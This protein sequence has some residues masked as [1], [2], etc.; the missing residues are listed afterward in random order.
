MFTF[1]CGVLYSFL[2]SK[3]SAQQGENSVEQIQTDG[4]IG[5]R[6]SGGDSVHALEI[7]DIK[8]V[9]STL[10]IG[11]RH[12]A[13][14]GYHVRTPRHPEDLRNGK[15]AGKIVVSD[16]FFAFSKTTSGLF[17]RCS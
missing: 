2:A 17:T 9:G 4:S 13:R 14:R 1:W 10:S 15:D 3:G 16:E 8:P 11:S 7:P 6:T 5:M 12:P